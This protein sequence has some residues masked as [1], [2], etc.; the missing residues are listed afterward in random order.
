MKLLTFLEG[1]GDQHSLVLCYIAQIKQKEGYHNDEV[2]R[3][4]IQYMHA[5]MEYN[6]KYRSLYRFFF[7]FFLLL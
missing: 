4:I 6:K 1:G 3:S 5:R 2:H 7:V